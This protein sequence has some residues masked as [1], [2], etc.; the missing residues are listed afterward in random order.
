MSQN[1]RLPEIL[2][3]ARVEGKV[4]VEGLAERLAVTAQTIRRDLTELAE[5][6]KLERVHGGAILRSGTRN[7]AYRERRALNAEAKRAIARACAQ[8]IPDGASVFLNIGTTTEAVAT[9]LASRR[10][11]LVVTNNMNVASILDAA[12]AERVI[13]T[14]GALRRG[15]GG[16]IG[17]LAIQ[18]IRQFRFD[19]AVI[20]CSALDARGDILDYDIQEVGTSQAILEQA[21]ATWLVADRSKFDRAAPARI[22]SLA[23]L[24]R[25]ITDALPPMP[26]PDRCAAWGVEIVLAETGGARDACESI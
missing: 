19:I 23:Q 3:I 24:D 2:E 6:G 5:A 7:I 21:R 22:G 26:V 10:D 18:T 11:L 14:G 15:D 8:A 1:F 9:E 12:G 13:L 4:T 20:G 16:L 25:F 17:P